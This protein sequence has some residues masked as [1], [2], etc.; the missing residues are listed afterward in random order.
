MT[1]KY[2]GLKSGPAGAETLVENRIAAAAIK[3][4][5]AVKD[6]TPGTGELDARVT[7]GTATTDALAGIVVQGDDRGTYG[8]SNEQA[9]SAAG[10][11]VGVAIIGRV[12]VKVDGSTSA[13]SIGDPLTVS[14]NDNGMLAKAGTGAFVVARARQTSSAYGD[15]ILAEVTRE[16]IL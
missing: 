4:G 3:I 12:K 11:S 7:P 5:G 8:G 14:T 13:I 1:D 9:A 2:P 6:T 16:G 15:Y 10:Q